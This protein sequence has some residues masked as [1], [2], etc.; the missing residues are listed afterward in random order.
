MIEVEG[1]LMFRGIMRIVPRTDKVKPFELDC[2]WLY[3]P[4][5]GCWYCKGSSY[6]ARICEIVEDKG[7]FVK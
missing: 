7:Y 4:E 2:A 5:T 6:P 3:K 1:Y